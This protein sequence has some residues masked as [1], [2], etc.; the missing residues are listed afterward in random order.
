MRYLFAVVLV[1]LGFLIGAALPD[2]DHYTPYLTH[3]SIVT[4]GAI[5][6]SVLF[7][8][9]AR[10]EQFIGRLF[11]VGLCV[12]SAVQVAFALFPSRW[13][14]AALLHIPVGGR[15][16][17]ELTVVWLALSMVVCLYMA[18]YLLH[19]GFEVALTGAVLLV[20][21]GVVSANERVFWH[22]LVVLVAALL[23]VLIMPSSPRSFLSYLKQSGAP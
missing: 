9:A 1:V 23:V 20:G 16:V 21:F 15:V 22:A 14:G 3:R 11:V 18:F 8:L 19:D 5:I 7:V 13:E 10:A 6:P 12:A 2:L 4:H 17:A